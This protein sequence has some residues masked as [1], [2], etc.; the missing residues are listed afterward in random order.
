[1]QISPSRP[2]IQFHLQA[3]SWVGCVFPLNFCDIK[4]LTNCPKYKEKNYKSKKKISIF[5]LRKENIFVGGKKTILPGNSEVGTF[6]K[7]LGKWDRVQQPT[8]A[9]TTTIA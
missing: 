6:G 5:G 9:A 2:K 1:M 7:N 8:R 4:N 3:L